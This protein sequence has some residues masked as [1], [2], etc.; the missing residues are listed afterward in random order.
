MSAKAVCKDV[1]AGLV[2][3]AVAAVIVIRCIEL[4]ARSHVDAADVPA[5]ERVS[6]GQ[7]C[8]ASDANS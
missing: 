4:Y 3:G 2:A 1:G 8:V 6:Q 5:V 7:T